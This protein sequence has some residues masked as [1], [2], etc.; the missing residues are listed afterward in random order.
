[1][2]K[3]VADTLSC[4]SLEEAARL[5][6]P[7]LPQIIEFGETAYRD[8]T[9][10]TSDI[11][12]Q[13]LR[14]SSALPKTAAPPPALYGPIFEEFIKAGHS[15]VVVSPSAEASG[16]FRSA[17]VA[18]QEFPQADIRVVDTKTIGSGLGIIVRKAVEWANQGL[19]ADTVVQKVQALAARENTYFLVDTLEYLQKGGRIGLAKALVGSILQVKPILTFK[20]GHTSPVESQRTKKRAMS[21][22]IELVLKDVSRS[23]D[24][25]ITLMEGDAKEDIKIW[26]AELAQALGIT[27]IPIYFLPPAILVHSGP[28][29]MAISYFTEE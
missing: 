16:T 13:K 15:I 27:G 25:N 19:D 3:I 12:L 20:G 1:M 22:L 18:A 24:A 9:E 17:E 4:I 29:A 26:Q 28:G 2:V 11:F 10:I 5:G 8:D 23:G 6:V 21:R 7:I 14:A